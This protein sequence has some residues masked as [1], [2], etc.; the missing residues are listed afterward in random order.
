MQVHKGSARIVIAIPTIHVAVKLPIIRILMVSKK[1]YQLIRRSEWDRLAKLCQW[2]SKYHRSF[3]R[4]LLKGI[5]DNWSEFFF[6]LCNRENPFPQA[7]YFSFF[8]LINLQRYDT[9]CDIPERTF[10]K[11]L[12]ELTN[13]TAMKDL[14]H[15]ENSNNFSFR[16][17]RLVMH[18]YGSKV[19]RA[20]IVLYGENTHYSF[21]PDYTFDG[22]AW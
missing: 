19:T 4:L 21:Y 20:I 3:K 17:G 9:P 22:K 18:D 6:Y 14:H 12:S 13:R 8:G 1:T 7:T 10:Y 16:D 2:N 5:L 11:Q 15:F